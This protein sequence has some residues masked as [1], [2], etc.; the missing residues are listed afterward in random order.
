MNQMTHR[1]IA[2]FAQAGK[3]GKTFVLAQIFEHAQQRG[4]TV[5][6]IDADPDHRSFSNLYSEAVR[7]DLGDQ[8]AGDF[9]RVL[10]KVQ[11]GVTILDPQAHKKNALIDAITHSGL[12]DLRTHRVTAVILPQDLIEVM[13]DVSATVA[14]LGNRVDWLVI[15][16]RGRAKTIRMYED[17]PLEEEL[18]SLGALKLEL[19]VLLQDTIQ[20]LAACSLRAGRAS[21]PFREAISAN[22]LGVHL[23]HAGILQYWMR[24]VYARLDAVA[25][26]L[27][28]PPDAARISAERAAKTS[29]TVP[30]VVRRATLNTDID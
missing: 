11:P 13:E 8:P 19:P 17:S 12:T 2:P 23:F 26:H 14:A 25:D 4:V 15:V 16:N 27:Y 22:N 28:L 3:I 29:V 7:L 1:I 10:T 6:G 18:N 30:S 20:H 21:I 24:N 5:A 9:L